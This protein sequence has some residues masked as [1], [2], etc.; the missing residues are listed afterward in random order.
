MKKW[1]KRI[2]Y[3]IVFACA[4]IVT[5][6]LF[7]HF[8]SRTAWFNERVEHVLK[9]TIGR[10][11]QLAR[12]GADF[13]G[14]YVQDLKI[15]QK[16][17]FEEGIFA[18]MGRLRARISLLHL[19]H[20]HTKITGIVLSNAHVKLIV[21]ADGTNNWQDLGSNTPSESEE[22][23]QPTQTTFNLTATR[24]RLEHLYVSYIDKKA[25]RTLEA[26]DVNLEVSNFSL[27]EEFPLSFW[28]KFQHQEKEF[29]RTIPIVIHANVNLAGL[30]MEQAYA[31]IQMLKATYQKSALVLQGNI[32]N[33]VAP[34]VDVKLK[35]TKF[36]SKLLEGLVAAPAFDLEQAT[37]E[38]AGNVDTSASTV[39]VRR[40]AVQAPG[41]EISGQGNLKYAG[42]LR[43]DFSGKLNTVLGELGRWFT[44]LADSYRLLGQ[45]QADVAATQEKLTIQL[46]VQDVGGY[47][48]QAGQLSNITGRLSGWEQMDG[49]KGSA[50][51]DLKGKFEANPFTLGVTL[52]QHPQKIILGLQAAAKELRWI[53]PA[54]QTETK[55]QQPSA[56]TSEKNRWPLPPIDLKANIDVDKLDVPYF[57]GTK[58]AFDADVQGFTPSLK[59]T[60]GMLRLQTQDGEIQDIYKLT[61]ANPLTKVLFMS[62]NVTGKVFNSLNVFGVLKSIGGG[63]VSAVSGEGPAEATEVKT[64]TILGPDGEPLEVPVVQTA[65]KVEGKMAY[66]KFDT[67]VNF[68]S[69]KATVKEGTFV[70]SMMSLRLDGTTDFNTGI[71]DLTVHAAPG[72]HEVNGMM[73]LTLKIGGTIEEPKGNMQLI[74]SVASLVTQT[75]TNN[76]VS[77]SVTKGIKGLFGLFKKDEEPAKEVSPSP[78]DPAET[79]EPVELTET[80][81]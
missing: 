59:Q 80:A 37:G 2:G 64:Q 75:V 69:G 19:L 33:F 71:V 52:D 12:I 44:A 13:R 10:E 11:I 43:Y 65:Q 61:N 38:L 60:H 1:T 81:K 6:D 15:A 36:S 51:V 4:G 27:Q 47:I 9:Q 58:I 26:N 14:I 24:L 46:D 25:S 62:L 76:V 53:M 42:K 16:G 79:T 54:S 41:L 22:P 77:R 68:D 32:K 67:Q 23:Q 66:D 3:L 30:N 56:Q 63:I 40:A 74:G 70:S 8:I 55:T 20:G 45:I 17:G 7:I 73:P 78:Q 31:T 72:R 48:A 18:Q 50:K 29:E 35:L 57:Y 39:T 5:L 28:A 34:Q 49:K 21:Q